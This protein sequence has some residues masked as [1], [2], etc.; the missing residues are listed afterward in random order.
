MNAHLTVLGRRNRGLDR[1]GVTLLF[2]VSTIVL[3]LLLT[4][5]FVLLS[6]QFRR[7]T[8]S[9]MRVQPR[10]DDAR[11]LVNRVFYDLLREPSLDNAHSPLRGH[12]ILGDIYGYGGSSYVSAA[13]FVPNTGNQLIQL[14]LGL[15]AAPP[16]VQSL[17]NP[18]VVPP[19]YVD[20]FE[21]VLY[22]INDERFGRFSDSDDAY[23]G[24]VLTFTS[25]PAGGISCRI[26]SYYV[27]F[28]TTV[29]PPVPLERLFVVMPEWNNQ[30]VA[31]L[32]PPALVQSR[33]VINNRPYSGTGA[34]AYQTT[35]AIDEAAL[36]GEALLPNRRGESRVQLINNYLSRRLS[37][38]AL[39]PNHRSTNEDYVAADFQ[40]MYLTN[41]IFDING[42]LFLEPAFH[43][44]ALSQ[45]HQ[46]FTPAP[47]SRYMF[48]VFQSGNPVVDN[49]GDGI[50]DGIWIDFG[51]P[52]HTDMR[53]RTVKPLVSVLCLDMDG[54]LNVNA[55]GNPRH[56]LGP[57]KNPL[58]L[59]GGGL[60]LS[61]GQ[62]YGPAEVSLGGAV[63]AAEYSALLFG[64]GGVLGRYGVNGTPGV[65]G[66]D[67]ASHY[68]LFSHPQSPYNPRGLTGNFFFSAMDIH[69]RLGWGTPDIVS[70]PIPVNPYLPA[71]LTVQIPDRLPVAD[72][73]GSALPNEIVESAYEF[74]FTSAP[75]SPSGTAADT[76]Y[77]PRELEAILRLYDPDNQMLSPRLKQHLAFS[78]NS[79]G[80]NILRNIL[81]TDSF[82]VP[83]PPASLMEKLESILR[84]NGITDQVVLNQQVRLM[85]GPELTKGLRLD[86][87]RPFGNGVDDGATDNA[88]GRRASV[89][90][91]PGEQLVGENFPDPYGRTF[92]FDANNDGV[93]D[94]F[95]TLAKH[96]FA[97]NLYVTTLLVT[98][99][100]DRDGNGV[101]NLADWY[102]YNGDGVV[103]LE[104]LYDYR[105]DVAQWAVNV[106]DFRDPDSIHTVTEMDLNPWDGWH[107]DG[108]LLTDES[109]T[110]GAD[111]FVVRGCERPEL[112][113]TEAWAL[114]LRRTED[115]D[116]DDG[117]GSRTTGAGGTDDD[118]DSR[119]VPNASVFVE[120]TNP[121]SFTGNA[122]VDANNQ[123]YPS[124]LYGATGVDLRRIAFDSDASLASPVWRMRFVRATNPI[125]GNPTAPVTRTMR[126]VDSFTIPAQDVLRIVYFAEPVHNLLRT[127]YPNKVYFPAAAIQFPEIPPGGRAVVGS[128]GIESGGN[129][130]TY[131][132]RRTTATWAT[133]LADTRS[134]TLRPNIAYA[135]N[136]V[137]LR[138]FTGATWA[139]LTRN[140]AAIPVNRWLGPA[141]G[142]GGTPRSLG[143]T[144]P[145]IGYAA[146]VAAIN[147]NYGVRAI[148]DGFEF[149]D[150]TT[151]LPVTLDEPID[152]QMQPNEWDA[153]PDNLSNPAA[154]LKDDGFMSGPFIVHLQRL[155]NPL[156]PYHPDANPYVTIDA[157]AVDLNVYN[158][159]DNGAET[160]AT[161]GLTNAFATFERGTNDEALPPAP[162]FRNLWKSNLDGTLPSLVALT[163]QFVNDQHYLAF[164]LQ[165]S[166][167]EIDLP[168]RDLSGG[169]NANTAFPWLTWNN[170]P[171]ATHLELA[172]VPFAA[173][174]QLTCKFDTWQN[175]NA[176]DGIPVGSTQWRRPQSDPFNHLFGFHTD[177]YSNRTITTIGAPSMHKV[178]DYLEV[179]SR[180][181]GTEKFLNPNVFSV[182]Q[183]GAGLGFSPPFNAISRYRY[184]GKI[185]LNTIPDF[186]VYVGLMGNYSQIVSF[187]DFIL[188]RNGPPST[189]PTGILYPYRSGES[190]NLVPQLDPSHPAGVHGLV[191]RSSVPTLFR[192]VDPSN[193]NQPLFDV[194]PAQTSFHNDSSRSA[195]FRYDMRQRLGNNVTTRSNVFAIWVTIG[196]FEVDPATMTPI[197]E[198]GQDDGSVQRYR[199]FYLIDRSIPVAFEPGFNHNVDQC[200]LTSSITEHAIKRDGR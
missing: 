177:A 63:S 185:N 144:D 46:T 188:S 61:L 129:Y 194:P 183:P 200:I 176:Y 140:A 38:G 56:V 101:V 195:Y 180:F 197:A 168:Y 182:G 113:I 69:G 190:S 93:L 17:I 55:H 107:V 170:R 15:D 105:R 26:V 119:L 139:T 81:T 141:P 131:L 8:M 115:R 137:E 29:S 74:D 199:G 148:T 159:A 53:G 186:R 62:G 91:E 108:N 59:L 146:G 94:Q 40:N 134:I 174:S 163:P 22:R 43:R 65:V 143:L 126:D 32:S 120:L 71:G 103:N 85:L 16:A 42:N 158:G 33:V 97:K 5:S 153:F 192:P 130:T 98:Q 77:S 136:Q 23:T 171:Y 156:R 18:A 172:M 9:Q 90:D 187:N 28:D 36:S 78:L 14:R 35:A 72:I 37:S 128:S 86:V 122:I 10:R 99:W 60:P 64:F 30:Q 79:A 88:T 50:P 48:D 173:P 76:P 175:R 24:Q 110:I 83:A 114:H 117:D 52:T 165:N 118:R 116:D 162:R 2:V 31:F 151:N 147:P 44:Q 54:N 111:R 11:T 12:S 164:N 184:P 132:G 13:Q 100:V 49:D 167:G 68:K 142:L 123:I 73:M 149:I 121:H 21:F 133:E 34:G 189:L 80:G 47:P 179:P 124:E 87:N 57:A 66:R 41:R 102:D 92:A 157:L 112:L 70:G 4:A 138:Y 191:T 181:V 6:A 127:E 198:L 84:Q 45:Y 154:G 135:A 150:T 89:V 152:K 145:V 196:F 109:G 75:F 67:L 169:F 155:A 161:G 95:D 3:F 106:A 125:P 166:W 27:V 20:T 51:L 160:D 25:G 39:I 1:R 104:D 58:P 19:P 178:L 7:S 193:P 82:D 96:H